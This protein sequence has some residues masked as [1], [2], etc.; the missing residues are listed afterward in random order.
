MMLR[1]KHLV[2]LTAVAG[3]L[4]LPVTTTAAVPEHLQKSAA[5]I[6]AGEY[7][8]AVQELDT[9]LAKN[10][11]DVLLL[12]LKGICLMELNR[13]GEAITIL[14]KAVK[15]APENVACRFYLAQA[16][17]YG[18]SISD[19]L[20]H[21][22]QIQ[23]L[24]PDSA[25]AER[26]TAA[27]PR[28]QELVA[29]AAPVPQK[30][31]RWTLCLRVAGEHDDNVAARSSAVESDGVDK[32]W[33]EVVSAYLEL[34]PLDQ[35]AGRSPVTIGTYVSGYGSHHEES[36]YSGYDVLVG[37]AAL[38]VR[39]SGSLGIPYSIDLTSSYT[40]VE[41]GEEPYSSTVDASL[42]IDLQLARWTVFAPKASWCIKDF[43]NDTTMPEL[44]SRDGE[45]M[46]YGV[47]QYLYLFGNKVTLGLGY[48][49]REVEADGELFDIESHNGRVVVYLSL[50]WKFRF[51]TTVSYAEEDYL[52][53]TPEPKRVDDSWNVNS[54]LSRPLFC[55][56]LTAEV[57]HTYESSESTVEFADY[58]RNVTGISLRATL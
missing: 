2:S 13:N 6:Q 35:N 9:L 12:R 23:E 28:L 34:R 11:E 55:N 38:F 14:A 44:Y 36:I 29:S 53:Y 48:E 47:D 1:F 57:S 10:P 43:E 52:D 7:Q 50:P 26:A 15:L 40:D 30:P 17:A 18:G 24:A 22:K 32:S 46:A 42:A 54:S 58:E 8:P 33:R 3:M 4:S 16:L 21:L 39:R 19:A 41:L 27:I 45:D 51:G 56:W 37:S 5:L 20:T 25:Y 49:Y 31:R